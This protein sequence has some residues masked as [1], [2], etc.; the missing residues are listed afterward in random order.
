MK[1]R[2]AREASASTEERAEGQTVDRKREVRT[3]RSEG[4]GHEVALGAWDACHAVVVGDAQQQRETMGMGRTTEQGGRK[5]QGGA[6]AEDQWGGPRLW[7][8]HEV[9][10]T[11]YYLVASPAL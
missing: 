1:E 11:I 3:W 2:E 10:G 5:G 8:H 9:H 6:E 4:E 7:T